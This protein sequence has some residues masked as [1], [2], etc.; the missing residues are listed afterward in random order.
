MLRSSAVA[1]DQ[2]NLEATSLFREYPIFP[3]GLFG[4]PLLKSPGAALLLSAF[5]GVVKSRNREDQLS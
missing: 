1:A 3:R 4:G 2:V 5:W